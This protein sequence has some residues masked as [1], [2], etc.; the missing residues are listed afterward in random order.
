MDDLAHTSIREHCGDLPDPR[1]DHTRRRHFLDVLTIALGALIGGAEGWTEV[2]AFGRAKAAW[3]RTCL[4]LPH[5]IPA[6]DTVGRSFAALD[7]AAFEPGFLGG[8]RAAGGRRARWWLSTASR[9]GART[10]RRLA[11]RPSIGSAPGPARTG[12][13]WAR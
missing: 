11:G 4:D 8:V 1:S 6:H 12:W 5:G 9:G 13:C 2:E 3:R 7:P 10:T